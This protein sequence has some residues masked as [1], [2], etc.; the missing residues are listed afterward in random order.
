MSGKA[1][2]AAFPKYTVGHT[3]TCNFG[4][5]TVTLTY[6]DG[7]EQCVSAAHL[8]V[9]DLLEVMS[10]FTESLVEKEDIAELEKA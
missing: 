1:V 8:T 6:V 3:E 4:P 5:T 2:R 10:E 7:R 9:A